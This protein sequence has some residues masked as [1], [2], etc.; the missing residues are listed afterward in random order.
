MITAALANDYNKDVAAIPGRKLDKSS[1]GCN[2]LIKHQQAHLIESGEDLIELMS[3]RKKT[4]DQNFQTNLFSEMSGEEQKIYKL[5][6]E[7]RE[8]DIDTLAFQSKTTPG[9]L[10]AILLSL[11]FKGAIKSLPGKKFMAIG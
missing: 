3:W 11:E 8:K 10:A 6:I 5:I 2:H 4:R 1:A 7:N 9:E